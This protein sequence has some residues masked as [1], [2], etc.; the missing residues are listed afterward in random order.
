[1]DPN[2][3]L[4]RFNTVVDHRWRAN[5]QT[6][7]SQPQ[8]QKPPNAAE[9]LARP[10]TFPNTT[11]KKK[12]PRDAPLSPPIRSGG[13][14]PPGKGSRI[15]V[16]RPDSSIR[17]AVSPVHLLGSQLRLALHPDPL[18][19][20]EKVLLPLLLEIREAAGVR[21][22]LE[23]LPA[24]DDALQPGITSS[25]R[26]QQRMDLSSK[27]LNHRRRSSAYA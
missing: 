7:R 4:F 22:V 8:R 1:M 9:S 6:G 10:A 14:L 15:T 13:R 11:P 2:I 20:H 17:L 24:P 5:H 23:L 16:T 21:I 19:N 18:A 3:H 27:P 26:A 25:T 12:R